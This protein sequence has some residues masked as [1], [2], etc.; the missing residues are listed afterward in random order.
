MKMERARLGGKKRERER[1]RDENDHGSSAATSVDRF[2]FLPWI[3][4][5]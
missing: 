3:H 4:P 5:L 2:V 1:S